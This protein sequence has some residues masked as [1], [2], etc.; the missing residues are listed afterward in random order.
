MF[1]KKKRLNVCSLNVSHVNQNI[2]LFSLKQSM[3]QR[4][5]VG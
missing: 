3:A 4:T 2:I 5:K 1:K